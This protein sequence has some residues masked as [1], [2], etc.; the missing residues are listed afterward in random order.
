MH[1]L[2]LSTPKMHSL[3]VFNRYGGV[4]FQT[5]IN[6]PIYK[7]SIYISSQTHVP[8]NGIDP[9]LANLVELLVMVIP[10]SGLIDDLYDVRIVYVAEESMLSMVSMLIDQEFV[11]LKIQE[12]EVNRLNEY[13]NEYHY[14]NKIDESISNLQDYCQAYDEK[15]NG[16]ILP[17]HIDYSKVIYEYTDEMTDISTQAKEYLFNKIK[18][19]IEKASQDIE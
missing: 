14:V 17:Q 16:T 4:D 12:D 1:T 19:E 11:L 6:N 9:R 13:C 15:V 3:L 10:G 5:L 2:N 8:K 18:L 7:H